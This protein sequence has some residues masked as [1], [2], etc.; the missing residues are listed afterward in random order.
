VNGTAAA[1]SVAISAQVAATSANNDAI[2]QL[3]LLNSVLG[4]AVNSTQAGLVYLMGQVRPAVNLL[5]S[6]PYNVTC[7]INGKYIKLLNFTVSLQPVGEIV[8]I[9][10]LLIVAPPNVDVSEATGTHVFALLR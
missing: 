7:N 4:N 1:P 5:L 3:Q 10:T 8:G 9:S 2:A 6:T